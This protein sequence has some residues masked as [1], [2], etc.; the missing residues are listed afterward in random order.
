ML[1]PRKKETWKTD[2]NDGVAINFAVE[3]AK[4]AVSKGGWRVD[5]E[6]LCS[7]FGIV[8][9]CPFVTST[10]EGGVIL[11]ISN[12]IVDLASWRVALIAASLSNSPIVEIDVHAVQLS[13]QHLLDLSIYMEKIGNLSVLKLDY[14]RFLGVSGNGFELFRP[15]LLGTSPVEYLSLKGNRFG[16]GF[17]SDPLNISAIVNNLTL[18][19]LSLSHNEIT[20]VGATEILRAIKLSPFIKELS[21]SR[22][23]VTGTCLVTVASTLNGSVANAEDEASLKKNSATINERIK[24]IKE[25][26]KKRKKDG[27]AE[28]VEPLPP[29]ERVSKVDGANMIANRTI[30]SVDL[31]F[32][33]IDLESFST[34][35]SAFRLPPTIAPPVP[36]STFKLLLNGRPDLQAIIGAG[37][38]SEGI[39]I[40]Y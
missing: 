7:T 40:C 13:P 21:L 15:F 27:K 26:N 18:Q 16:D 28:L 4:E 36:P 30:L 6:S 14:V 11:R 33:P 5:F 39:T 24:T 2:I 25:L 29:A 38:I 10:G 3:V 9:P 17:C 22:N 20:D 35:L 12:C 1:S 32:C 31:S 23:D 34:G 8:S 37:E 19:A